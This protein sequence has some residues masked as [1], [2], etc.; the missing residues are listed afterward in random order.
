VLLLLL[1]CLAKRIHQALDPFFQGSTCDCIVNLSPRQSLEQRHTALIVVLNPAA[2]V[3]P[4]CVL[5]GH[6]FQRK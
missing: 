5:G 6:E 2:G 4:I 3:Q 1:S